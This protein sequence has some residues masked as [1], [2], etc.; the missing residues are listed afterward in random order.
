MILKNFKI[1][2]YFLDRWGPWTEYFD[3]E[4]KHPYYFNSITKETVWKLSENTKKKYEREKND[5]KEEKESSP[6][7]EKKKIKKDSDDE[8]KKSES[9]RSPSPR[10]DLF[11]VR[12]GMSDPKKNCTVL[13]HRSR[14]FGAGI[15]DFFVFEIIAIDI[16][17]K[18]S[19][20]CS[21]TRI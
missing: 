15:I 2:L 17:A 6:K 18:M 10:Y 11:C 16:S 13:V 5:E 1:N 12:P 9:R 14:K 19:P 8:M 7:P 21:Q 20:L 4:T 3:Q